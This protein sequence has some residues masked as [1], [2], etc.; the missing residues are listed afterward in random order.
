[1]IL[2]GTR[3]AAHRG[4]PTGRL[5]LLLL[6]AAA[7]LAG[8]QSRET[9]ATGSV[10]SDGYRTT[11]PIALTE[12]P[13]TLDIPVGYGT[14]GLSASS[15]DNVRAF[16]AAA[17]EH[18]TGSLVILTPAGS[19]N[20]KAASHM[21]QEA[22]TVA[23]S[24][25]LPSSLIETRSYA[26]QDPQANAPIR[27]TYSRIKAVSPPCGEWKENALIGFDNR[28]AAE[29][30]CSTQANLAAMVENPED[31]ITPRATTPASATRRTTQIG[32]YEAA[33]DPTGA[34]KS[35]ETSNGQ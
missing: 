29:F 33:G 30:G 19:A 1:M 8:C 5:T 17:A 16:A 10:R 35:I 34:W 27:L 13:E 26:V 31:L 6:A 18:G 32:K 28:D 23:R 7:A 24:G 11:Y 15:R 25:G 21:A 2:K 4:G 22:R 14:S 9:L 20:Q 12:A 3:H